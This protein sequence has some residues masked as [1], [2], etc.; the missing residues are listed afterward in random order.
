MNEMG[1]EATSLFASTSA[2]AY[3][4]EVWIGSDRVSHF[5]WVTHLFWSILSL[6]ARLDETYSFVGIPH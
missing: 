2:C 1:L 4:E 3:T 5:V 6:V